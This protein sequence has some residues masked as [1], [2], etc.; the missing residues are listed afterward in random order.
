MEQS[1]VKIKELPSIRV[2][3]ALAYGASPEILS[4]QT[5]ITW[6][7]PLGLL[8]PQK[9]PH[10]FGFN[11][12]NPSYGTPNYGYETWLVVEK[13]VQASGEIKIKE[14]PGMLCAV[15]YCPSVEVITETWNQLAAWVETSPYRMADAQCLEETFFKDYD[16]PDIDHFYLWL[17]VIKS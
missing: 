2:A 11:N 17:P 5:L 12:P 13:D 6:A 1:E 14:I 7:K 16:I 8:E 9:N 15:L 4:I 3:S 10:F